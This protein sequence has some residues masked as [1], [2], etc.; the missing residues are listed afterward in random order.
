MVR[1]L[2][3]QAYADTFGEALG[4]S[5]G[6]RLLKAVE[7]QGDPVLFFTSPFDGQAMRGV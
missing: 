5:P 7:E 3:A 2:V 1:L 4:A 6:K